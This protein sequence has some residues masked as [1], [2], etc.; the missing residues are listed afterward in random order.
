MKCFV[1]LTIVMFL[2]FESIGCSRDSGFFFF[3]LLLVL[4]FKYICATM[5]NLQR[6][7]LTFGFVLDVEKVVNYM[8][9]FWVCCAVV[10]VLASKTKYLLSLFG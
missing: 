8:C 1:M 3:F 6:C 10:V 9:S 5:L 7:M 2:L 4:C